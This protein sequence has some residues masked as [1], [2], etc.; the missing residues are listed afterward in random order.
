[1][2]R[3]ISTENTYK[4]NTYKGS[5]CK[6][7]TNA[8]SNGIENIGNEAFHTI[9]G[10]KDMVIDGYSIS[11]DEA[12][13]LAGIPE[14]QLDELCSAADEIQRHFFGDDFDMCAVISVKGGR[15]SEN[16]RYCAQSSCAN[17]PVPAHSMI[18]PDELFSNAMLRNIDG[19]RHYCLVSTGRRVSDRDIDYICNGISRV[20]HDTGLTVCTSFGL[21]TEPQL[22]RLKAAGVARI[23]NNLET[24]RRYFPAL[25]T[26]HT[27]DEKIATI[28]AARKAGLE[29]CSGGIF[30]VGETME[31]R[32]DMALTLRSLDVQSVPVNMLDPV[33]GT[34]FGDT[35]VLTRNEVRRIIAIYRFIL[36]K[37]Y[38]RL[39]AGRDYLDDS[40]F[41]CFH[42]G[43]NATI[44][45]D[46]LTVKGISIKEDISTI[47]NMGYRL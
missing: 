30:G 10:L 31:D 6:E 40:G 47:K 7:S 18:S 42:S 19:I 11:R 14:Q 39:A 32:I 20:C 34:P 24:S 33:P 23:H 27:Y 29:V 4:E 21:L 41:S 16:C 36:P 12:L 1:M 45:G 43:S 37:Q 38:I 8:E 9:A 25:C 15:C 28:R 26:S 44:T 2:D 22:L 5:T 46:M 17:V 35:P 13:F 3:N